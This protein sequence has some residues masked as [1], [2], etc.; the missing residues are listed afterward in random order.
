MSVD[1]RA[2]PF[3]NLLGDIIRPGDKVACVCSSKGAWTHVGT[4]EGFYVRPY[5]YYTSVKDENTGKWVREK[6]ET[7]SKHC[8]VRRDDVTYDWEAQT[9][10][11]NNNFVFKKADKPE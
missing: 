6:I 9:T 7:T 4:Y 10:I 11:L 1:F 2:E 3:V 5:V 8:R